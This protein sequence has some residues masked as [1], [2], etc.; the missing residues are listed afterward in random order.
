M[1]VAATG[2]AHSAQRQPAHGSALE[3]RHTA[4]GNVLA[5]GNGRTLYLFEADKANMSNC[6]G[7]CLSLWPPFTSRAKPQAKGGALAAKVAAIPGTRQVT[8][9]GHPLYYYVADRKP[10]DTAGQGLNQFGAKWYAVTSTG[11]KVDHG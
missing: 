7:A 11:E 6:A 8:Y 1:I 5:D 4:L 9:N 3:V 2:G 10:G